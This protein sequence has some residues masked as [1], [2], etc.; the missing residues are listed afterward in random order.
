MCKDEKEH[1][2]IQFI[3][4][5]AED[6]N[7]DSIVRIYQEIRKYTT[8]EKIKPLVNKSNVKKYMEKEY[9]CPI[10]DVT[11]KMGY[12]YLHNISKKHLRKLS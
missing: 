4:E 1:Q 6:G 7:N 5:L 11:M 9:Y 3:K 8:S 2:V 10:C 12:K